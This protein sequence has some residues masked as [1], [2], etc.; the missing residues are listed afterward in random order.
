MDAG[1]P[2]RAGHPAIPD[3]T[4]HP[5]STDAV[6][7]L[8]TKH[9]AAATTRCPSL[10]SKHVTPHVL[11]HAQRAA[12]I[13]FPDEDLFVPGE[14][15]Q[16]YA[17]RAT[18]MQATCASWIDMR[19]EAFTLCRRLLARP[20]I[21]DPDR[22]RIAANRD[23]SVPA[24]IDAVTPY[25]E[26]LAQSLAAGPG[27]AQLTVSLIAGPDRQ[28]PSKPSTCFCTCCL[29]VSRVGR[30]LVLD[31]GLPAPDRALLQQ[32]YGFLE[33]APSIPSDQPAAQLAALRVQINGRFWLHLG[34]GWRFFAPENYI[35]RLTAVLDAEPQVFQVGINVAD[36]AKL[37]GASAAEGPAP[38]ARC[39]PLPNHR[40]GGQRPGDLR[41]GGGPPPDLE[42]C[43]C[44]PLTPF[45]TGSE[46]FAT[47]RLAAMSILPSTSGKPSDPRAQNW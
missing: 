35:T 22:Q 39:R 20:D 31:T 1:T 33:F 32:R 18:D 42:S 12:E 7:S 15:E 26:A 23:F 5:T 38:R 6:E 14:L 29:D 2:R 4:R 11:R 21:P 19:A 36:E 34:E 10:A 9:A 25:P 37:T 3:P 27:E 41:H 8:V 46:L 13:P 16:V 17:W 30:F 47:C 43:S 40:C 45:R 24:M 28:P 44:P